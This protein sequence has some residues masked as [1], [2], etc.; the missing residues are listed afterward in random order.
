M[1]KKK[2]LVIVN[3]TKVHFFFSF[4]YTKYPMYTKSPILNTNSSANP[5][6]FSRLVYASMFLILD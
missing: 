1:K 3:K 5:A 4:L 2:N 6:W